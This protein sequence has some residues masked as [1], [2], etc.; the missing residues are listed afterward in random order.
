MAKNKGV[1]LFKVLKELNVARDTLVQ[2]LVSK[3][4]TLEDTSPNAQLPEEM[5]E[6]ALRAFAEDRAAAMLHEKRVKQIRQALHIEDDAAPPKTEEEPAPEQAAE[7]VPAEPS[8]PA[9][10]TV[11]PEHAPVEFV[12]PV[13]EE[14]HAVGTVEAGAEA[15]EIPV[16]TGVTEAVAGHEEEETAA[17]SEPDSPDQPSEI[18]VEEESETV[19]VEAEPDETLAVPVL[20]EED[21]D[22]D[23]V[24]DEIPVAVDELVRAK[25]Y[26][27]SGPKVV[28]SMDLESL[29][30]DAAGKK[31]RKRKRKKKEGDETDAPKPDAAVAPPSTSQPDTGPSKRKRKRIRGPQVDESEVER[32]LHETLT[33]IG[34]GASRVRQR[35]RRA[36]REEHAAERE[37]EQQAA[38]QEEGIIRVMEFVSANEL[39]NQMGVSVTDVI[40]V[41]LGLGMMVSINQRLDAD[42]ISLIADE[43]EF[44]VEFITDLGTDDIEIEEDLPEDL[45]PRAPVVT[46]M[47]HV[48]HGK[49]SLLDH[50]RR[51]NVVAGESGGI[52]QHIGAYSVVLDDGRELTFLDTPGH[53][54]FTAMRARGAQVTD[55]VILV[56]AAD[57][58]VMPQTIEA[59]NHAKAAGTPIVVAVNKID[60]P[61]ANTQ[62]VMQEL[63][64]QNVLVEPYG[65]Q[66]QCAFVSAKTG[67]GIPDLLD[68]VLVEAEILNLMANPE[69]LALGTVVESR[70]DKGR[71]IVATVL[72]QNGTLKVGDAFVAGAFS[73]R[74]RAMYDERE[75]RVESAGPASP[76]LIVGF[77]GSPEAG[78]RLVVV[79]DEREAREIAQRRQQIH[80]EQSLRR[81]KHIALDDIG[82]RM[83]LGE[84]Q[85]L[86]I[87]VKGDVAG[88][89][90][91]LTD[92]LMKIS[93][94]EVKVT[95]IHTGVGAITESDVMLASASDAVIIG[96]QVRPMPGVRKLAEREEIDVRTYSIIYDA[97][98]DVRD[99]LEGMLAPEV[100]EKTTGLVDVRETFRVPKVGTV[101]GCYVLEGKIR[102]MDTVHVIRDGVVIYTAKLSTLKRFKEDAREV[103]SGYECGLTIENFND[104]KIGDQIEAFEMV[105]TR[106]QL[107]V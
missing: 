103:A 29:P 46:V 107:E 106:R 20:L 39:A 35:R 74:V 87:I 10:E 96:F 73:G 16:E 31:K 30:M 15:V 42:A 75:N 100:S 19:S 94:S 6:E 24:E 37:R 70:L 33:E 80:R 81:R 54:A 50:I 26:S 59:I 60:K 14:D 85:E 34:Q 51:A 12:E 22:D 32:S 72:V 27:L 93:S 47:G 3:G 45:K 65:G 56:V 38:A 99:A 43:F 63:A 105:E 66:V 41:C 53:E 90:E 4:F 25:R 36:R 92:S 101:A 97:I 48:D 52:T 17:V 64:D 13:S 98:A 84:L 82:R 83:A 44:D 1:R 55:V 77:S 67:E 76:A 49:T 91:A 28:G 5:Y 78:D 18:A 88:S 69:R 104:I 89:V 71:G 86:G 61:S 8:V 11:E 68:K 102:R 95:I 21:V 2:H 79:E 58:A 9:E 40:R 23:E 62:R 7:P 57:D